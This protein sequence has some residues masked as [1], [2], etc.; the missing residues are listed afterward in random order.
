VLDNLALVRNEELAEL[1]C[2]RYAR[3][4]NPKEIC[5][6]DFIKE[7]EDVNKVEALAVKGI[8]PNPQNVDPNKNITLDLHNDSLTQ[9]FYVHKRLP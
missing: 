2:K 4:S 1:L 9:E 8:V 6:Q 5:Y 3:S 7:I